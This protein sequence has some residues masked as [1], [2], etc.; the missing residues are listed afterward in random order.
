[1]ITTCDECPEEVQ[2]DTGDWVEIGGPGLRAEVSEALTQ[3]EGQRALPEDG[4][5]WTKTRTG[6]ERRA[7]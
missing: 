1:M 5:T 6:A 3:R 2:E 4:R 7:E